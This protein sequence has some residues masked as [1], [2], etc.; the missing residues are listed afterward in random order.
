MDDAGRAEAAAQDL[1]IRKRQIVMQ[2]D[3]ETWQVS[4]LVC[5]RITIADV[6]RLGTGGH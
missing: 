6:S 2:M 5:A 1:D 4:Y 3:M